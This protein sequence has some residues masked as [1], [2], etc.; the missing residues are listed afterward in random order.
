M[1]VLTQY[2]AI[3][4]FFSG[5]YALWLSH[6]AVRQDLTILCTDSHMLTFR[7][8][9]YSLRPVP[10]ESIRLEVKENGTYVTSG[11]SLTLKDMS[12]PGILAPESSFK[13]DY[14]L[15]QLVE[16][17]LSKKYRLTVTS[18]TGNEFSFEGTIEKDKS[19]PSA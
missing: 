12:L 2:M 10:I 9:N 1:D 11:G 5:L 17:F 19:Q 6:K 16:I 3:V 18:Q 15:E 8:V 7:V 14:A 4:G 13:I